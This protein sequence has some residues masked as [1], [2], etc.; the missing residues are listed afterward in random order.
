[1]GASL[2]SDE[3]IILSACGTAAIVNLRMDTDGVLR[4]STL[5]QS[6]DRANFG[7]ESVVVEGSGG[8]GKEKK[9]HVDVNLANQAAAHTIRMASG[10]VTLPLTFSID[11]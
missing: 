6:L 4:T 2:F 7:K 10:W 11:S 3:L 8:S 9:L 5:A 1:M